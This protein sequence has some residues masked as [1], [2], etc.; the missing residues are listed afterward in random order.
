MS[1]VVWF[2]LEG[3]GSNTMNMNNSKLIVRYLLAI[4]TL[5]SGGTFVIIII[6]R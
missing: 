1:G 3:S 6:I 4:R 5:L 2:G